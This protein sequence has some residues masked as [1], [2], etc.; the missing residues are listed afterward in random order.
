MYVSQRLQFPPTQSRF[1]KKRWGEEGGVDVVKLLVTKD[2]GSMAVG[3]YI[4]A[5]IMAQ[6]WWR[7]PRLHLCWTSGHWT[8][9]FVKIHL[10]WA[11]SVHKEW[12][13]SLELGC[14]GPRSYQCLKNVLLKTQDD[15]GIYTI[16]LGALPNTI[17]DESDCFSLNI[18]R[19]QGPWRAEGYPKPH[20]QM[21]F[22]DSRPQERYILKL[23]YQNAPKW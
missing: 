15:I 17:G 22:W 1:Q 16:F 21:E 23:P 9:V 4:G 10:D 7:V 3:S 13:D 6:N 8:L 2:S 11:A 18:S 5:A 20:Y 14:P 12:P 19:L